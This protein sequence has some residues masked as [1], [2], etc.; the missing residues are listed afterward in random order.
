MKKNSSVFL[1]TKPLQYFNAS[2]I[3]DPNFRICLI[4]NYF[5]NA[6][7]LYN[8][9]KNQST[10]WDEILFFKNNF[11]ALKWVIDNINSV[12]KLYLDG[13]YGFKKYFYLNKLSGIDIYVY[14]EGEASY[15]N[16]L[17][18]KSIRNNF[19][20]KLFYRLLGNHDYL[21]GYKNTKGIYV[22]DIQKH[23]CLK[24]N[25]N[26]E[27]RS[28]GEPFI[29]HLINFRDRDLFLNEKSKEIIRHLKNQKVLLYLSG[30]FTSKSESNYSFKNELNNILLQYPKHIKILKPHPHIK[31]DSDEDNK[32]FDF[33]ITGEVLAEYFISEV[34]NEAEE[35]IVI[36]HGSSALQYFTDQ[37]K[38]KSIIL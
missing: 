14:E 21:G 2:N 28:F 1:V 4:V 11:D 20:I 37:K 7:T 38:I 12:N 8:K 9:I 29:R 10:Y 26:K 16:N 22:Y 6:E 32:L 5:T 34:L 18:D 17:K 15:Y 36:H 30:W 25:Y 35:L 3:D 19:L 33:L 31:T 27:I 24:P 23:K 13:D